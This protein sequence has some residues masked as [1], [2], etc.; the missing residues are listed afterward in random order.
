MPK[1]VKI[2]QAALKK[3]EQYPQRGE[4]SPDDDL[5]EVFARSEFLKWASSSDWKKLVNELKVI[6]MPMVLHC[7]LH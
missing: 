3:L 6:P 4:A 5:R 7:M 2:W 1:A